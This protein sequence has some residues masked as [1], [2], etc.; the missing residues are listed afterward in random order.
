MDA[1]FHSVRR[2]PQNY[3][4]GFIFVLMI[5]VKHGVGHSLAHG[6]VD[7]VGSVVADSGAAYELSH[8]GSR[9]GNRFDSA[10]QT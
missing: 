10:G 1:D 4:Y 5:A 7:T 8:G 2:A 3:V 6:H 9:G